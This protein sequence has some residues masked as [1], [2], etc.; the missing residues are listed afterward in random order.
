MLQQL[1]VK[2]MMNYEVLQ[3]LIFLLNEGIVFMKAFHCCG[4]GY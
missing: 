3:A 2:Q 4:D 1:P